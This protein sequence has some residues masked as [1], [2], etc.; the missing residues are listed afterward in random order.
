VLLNKKGHQEILLSK[1]K[2]KFPVPLPLLLF[3]VIDFQ[4]NTEDAQ[5]LA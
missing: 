2:E 3:G 1:L 4:R 5:P